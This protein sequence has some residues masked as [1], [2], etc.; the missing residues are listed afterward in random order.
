[1]KPVEWLSYSIR[2]LRM[3]QTPPKLPAEQDEA[4][5]PVMMPPSIHQTHCNNRAWEL[6][7]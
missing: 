4:V 1:M 5:L 6:V 7:E 3:P 2:S